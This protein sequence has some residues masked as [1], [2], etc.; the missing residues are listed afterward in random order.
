MVRFGIIGAGGISAA[1][2]KAAAVTDGVM[3]SAV[4]AQNMKRAQ[5]FAAEHGIAHAY[6]NYAQLLSD[7][8]VDAVYIGNTTNFHYQCIKMC[9]AAGK[10]VLCEKAMVETEA[11][12]VECFDLARSKGLFLMEAMWARFLPKS[13]KVRDWVAEG[14]IGAVTGVQATIGNFVEKDPENR[15]YS[16]KLGGGAMYDLGVYAID[17]ISYFTGKDI[18]GWYGRVVRAQTGVDET[19]SLN[20]DLEGIPAHALITFNAAVPEDCYI[21]GEKGVIRVPRMHWGSDAVLLDPMMNEKERFSQPEENG[22]RFE[23]AEA[24]YCIGN[25]MCTSETAPPEMTLLSSRIYDDL[26]GTK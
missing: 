4:A 11:R 9:L 13:E 10:H 1:F 26:L 8:S 18:T 25:G 6:G 22:M 5:L 16:P 14:R 20:L 21:Y 19:V 2:A 17:L 24:A 12:A 15:F 7:R 3:I 23:I